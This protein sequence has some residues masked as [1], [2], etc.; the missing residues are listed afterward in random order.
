[1]F[2]VDCIHMRATAIEKPSLWLLVDRRKLASITLV[3]PRYVREQQANALQSDD[4]IGETRYMT[5]Y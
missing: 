4:T 5:S 2:F 3:A 1:M